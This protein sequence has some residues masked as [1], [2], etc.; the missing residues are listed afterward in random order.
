MADMH[1]TGPARGNGTS[2]NLATAANWLGAAMSLALVIGVAV[3]GY[4]LVMRDVSGVPVVRAIEGPM[5]VAPDN[6]GGQIARHEGLAVNSVAG[7]GT[8]APPPDQ[9]VLA[10]RPLD[11]TEEDMIVTEITDTRTLTPT[12]EMALASLR[13]DART[14]A[15]ALALTDIANADDPIRALADQIAANATPFTEIAPAPGTGVFDTQEEEDVIAAADIIPP[16]VP[17]VARSLRPAPRPAGLQL[18]SL[19]APVSSPVSSGVAEID[20]GAIP[21]GTRLVQFGAFDSPDIAREQWG[22]LS[23]RFG[24]F[25]TGKERVIE[26]ATS[27]GRVFYRLRAH[28]FEDLSESRR[29]C[30]ALVAEGADCIPVVSR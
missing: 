23:A 20:P 3:W 24:E 4:R 19:S 26:E 6:P 10:P 11:I 15:P 25:L 13:Q 5:R 18:A 14:E 16:S 1:M 29:F 30:A 22:K 27:G 17:G 7:T 28:G 9:I 2:G 8:S 12:E 21:A